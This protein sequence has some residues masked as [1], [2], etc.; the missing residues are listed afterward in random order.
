M[1]V[2]HKSKLKRLILNHVYD[3][4]HGVGEQKLREIFSGLPYPVEIAHDGDVFE[5]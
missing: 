5:V 3:K 4:W 1:H 2:F